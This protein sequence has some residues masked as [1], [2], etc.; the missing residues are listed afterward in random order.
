VPA[1][2]QNPPVNVTLWSPSCPCLLPACVHAQPA[3]WN[4]ASGMCV[5]VCVWPRISISETLA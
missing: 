5:C 2:T 3:E 4:V 1:R